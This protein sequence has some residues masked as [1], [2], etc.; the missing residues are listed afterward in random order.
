MHLILCI[1]V[2]IAFFK[3]AVSA[4]TKLD[5]LESE[6]VNL[7]A[8]VNAESIALIH[9]SAEEAA[10]PPIRQGHQ[11]LE[12]AGKDGSEGIRQCVCSHFMP[13]TNI[14]ALDLR[15]SLVT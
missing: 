13:I 4:F 15:V 6:L 12:R 11:I 2:Q 10:R 5:R 9:R 3:N 8:A 14:V 7:P 1:R